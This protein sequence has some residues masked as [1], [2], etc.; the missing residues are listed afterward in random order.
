MSALTPYS[1]FLNVPAVNTIGSAAEELRVHQRIENFLTH[2]RW[3][4]A[5][6][7]HL[8]RAQVQARHLE[9]FRADPFQLRLVRHG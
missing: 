4:A 9:K 2:W 1:S 6:A 8:F 5:Q 7:P 3:K